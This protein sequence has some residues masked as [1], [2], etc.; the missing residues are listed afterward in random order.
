MGLIYL[1]FYYGK[2]VVAGVKRTA[3]YC[4]A[5]RR[6]HRIPFSQIF[7][8][9]LPA[10]FSPRFNTV[11]IISGFLT[12]IYP[13]SLRATT[14]I[15]MSTIVCTYTTFPLSQMF[16]QLSTADLVQ[17]ADSITIAVKIALY[18]SVLIL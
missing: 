15:K 12:D 6:Q 16:P 10:G 9:L 2:D 11:P 7:F 18:A 4:F 3:L 5:V 17:A 14:N 8:R 13:I 1:C